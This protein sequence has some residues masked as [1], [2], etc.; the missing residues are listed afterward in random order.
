MWMQTFQFLCAKHVLLPDNIKCIDKSSTCAA[1]ATDAA[2]CD[3]KPEL[4]LACCQT[5]LMHKLEI[6]RDFPVF[7]P[8]LI[9]SKNACPV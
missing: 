2:A 6:V 5:C 8:S 3:A 4:K 7:G 1:D 9:V